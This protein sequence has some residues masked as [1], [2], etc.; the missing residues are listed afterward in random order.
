MSRRVAVRRGV[1][2]NLPLRVGD[3][4]QVPLAALL[5]DGC[6]ATH[7]GLA[8]LGGIFCAPPTQTSDSELAQVEVLDQFR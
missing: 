1:S 3:C 2:P 8:G 4:L 5:H 6:L 7:M